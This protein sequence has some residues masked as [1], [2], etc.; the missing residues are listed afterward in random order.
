MKFSGFF[1]IQFGDFKKHKK[2]RKPLKYRDLI[3]TTW[4]P[5]FCLSKTILLPKNAQKNKNILFCCFLL[6]LL[7]QNIGFYWFSVGGLLGMILGTF[8]AP[9]GPLGGSRGG[10]HLRS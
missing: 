5:L 9:V 8:L 4:K 2:T 10:C 1:R 6:V 7:K 3:G